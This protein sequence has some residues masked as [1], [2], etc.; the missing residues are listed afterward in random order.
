MNRWL[1]ASRNYLVT[2]YT[3]LG[4]VI[5]PTRPEVIR[6][7]WII[8]L[9]VVISMVILGLVDYGLTSLLQKVVTLS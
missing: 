7:T 1:A 5:W 6:H 4:K 8:V 2:A 3:E 9:S